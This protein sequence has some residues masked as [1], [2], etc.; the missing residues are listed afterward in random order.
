MTADDATPTTWTLTLGP[1]LQLDWHD[2]D[3]DDD[4][5]PLAPI[6]PTAEE[7]AR[8]G[9]YPQEVRRAR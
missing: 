4:T 1:R 9:A 5:A 3:A 2:A 6:S 7:M 8:M